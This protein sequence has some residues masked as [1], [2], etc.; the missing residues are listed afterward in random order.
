MKASAGSG[1]P[2]RFSGFTAFFLVFVVGSCRDK[3]LGTPS[4]A[5]E[6][7]T[8][9]TNDTALALRLDQAKGSNV[10]HGAFEDLVPPQPSDSAKRSN[11]FDF[12]PDNPQ[13][14]ALAEIEKLKLRVRS[15]ESDLGS[16]ESAI[17]IHRK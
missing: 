6:S 17:E 1:V 3:P 5:S 9:S 8:A 10:V 4:G 15:L 7:K 16:A 12:V 14:E 11:V 13:S 2:V